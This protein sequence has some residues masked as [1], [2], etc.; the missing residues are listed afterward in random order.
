M[1]DDYY[2]VLGLNRDAGLTQI[3]RAY[4][5]LS[6]R[7]HPDVAGEEGVEQFERIRNAYQTLA[8]TARRADYDRGLAEAERRREIARAG[9]PLFGQPVDLLSD[10]ENVRP[11]AEDILHHILAGISGHTAK[12]N[13]S[14]ELAVDLVLTPDQAARGG[15]VTLLVPVARVCPRCGGNGRTG[16]FA[17]DAC[18]GQ[19]TL[20][21]KARV[22]VH[23]PQNVQDGATIETSLRH[24]GIRNMWLKTNVHVAPGCA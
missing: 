3:R 19:G 15:G 20:W 22:D 17:C 13:P 7:F 11:G 10:Y 23:V 4:R 6:V 1:M 18:A 14:R 12:S 8:N 5:R 21:Q 9:Q 16:F 2:L 24:V